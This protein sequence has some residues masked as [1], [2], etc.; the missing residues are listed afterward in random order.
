MPISKSYVCSPIKA[1]KKEWNVERIVKLK[2]STRIEKHE[3]LKKLKVDTNG[4]IGP[5]QF[6][7]D[8]RRM[9]TPEEQVMRSGLS[10]EE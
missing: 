3:N 5:L 6:E 2:R 7:F 9:M 10:G 8:E 4:A 1:E